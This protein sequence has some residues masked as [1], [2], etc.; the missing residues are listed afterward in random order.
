M[1]ERRNRRLS[2]LVG[3]FLLVVAAAAGVLAGSDLLAT[4][5][6]LVQVLLLG[7]AGV[8]DL[9][10]TGLV[11]LPDGVA[12]YQAS[13]LGNVLLGVSLPLGFSGTSSL[14]LLAVTA[15]GGF[16]LAAM[17]IDMLAFHGKYTRGERLDA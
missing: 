15:V 2:G 14:A 4:P 6:L 17:G 3:A 1:D 10:A 9:A 13:G 7:L 12:W 5:A 16:A 11:G 8:C